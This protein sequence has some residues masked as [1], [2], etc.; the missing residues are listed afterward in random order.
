MLRVLE[1]MSLEAER[2]RS[3]YSIQLAQVRKNSNISMDAPIYALASSMIE[4]NR[5]GAFR[6]YLQMAERGET[7]VS[8][9]RLSDQKSYFATFCAMC[10]DYCYKA[11]LTREQDTLQTVFKRVGYQQNATGRTGMALVQNWPESESSNQQNQAGKVKNIAEALGLQVEAQYPMGNGIHL[12]LKDPGRVLNYPHPMADFGSRMY[13]R[14]L[15]VH[16]LYGN[17]TADVL[18]SKVRDILQKNT[19]NSFL[20]LW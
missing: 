18:I 7:E 12:D 10:S 14:G 13:H 15:Q 17:L 2:L 4:K 3:E 6:S 9:S 20:I 16:A 5:F 1:N 19:Q 11:R 8:E